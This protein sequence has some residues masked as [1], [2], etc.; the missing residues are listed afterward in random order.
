MQILDF[1]I[2]GTHLQIQ[3]DTSSSCDEDFSHIRSYLTDFESRFSR[4]I[5]GNW[6]ADV[7]KSRS[8]ILDEDAKK[9]LEFM[10]EM[11]TKTDGYFDPTVGKS[12]TELG[13]G[14]REIILP[15]VK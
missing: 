14:N 4:F 6:L 7:N 12:L 13:Y 10:L 3:I 1:D 8:G 2:I 9:M 11:A 5:D 15:D